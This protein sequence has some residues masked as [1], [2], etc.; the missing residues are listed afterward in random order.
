MDD[1]IVTDFYWLT[2]INLPPYLIAK[3]KNDSYFAGSTFYYKLPM[4]VDPEKGP[5]FI[6]VVSKLLP[7]VTH[8]GGLIFMI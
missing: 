4:A 3:P 1:N 7:F 8:S 5:V 2:V 6:K